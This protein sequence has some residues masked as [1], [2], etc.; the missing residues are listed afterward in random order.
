MKTKVQLSIASILICNLVAGC[1]A[2]WTD[3]GTRNKYWDAHGNELPMVY[4]QEKQ[5]YVASDPA[6][7]V[8]YGSYATCE[9]SF[10]ARYQIDL[11]TV[12]E[13]NSNVTEPLAIEPN[14]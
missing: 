8:C 14:L 7:V 10:Y 6:A 11:N 4:D 9:S 12:I 3:A 2:L 1:S 5:H 13:P